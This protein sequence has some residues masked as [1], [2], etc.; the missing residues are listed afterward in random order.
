MKVTARS[1]DVLVFFV[2]RDTLAKLVPRNVIHLDHHCTGQQ[3]FDTIEP[4]E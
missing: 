3:W 1:P 4:S 2:S